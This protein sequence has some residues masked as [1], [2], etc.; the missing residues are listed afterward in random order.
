[1]IEA[2]RAQKKRWFEQRSRE[3]MMTA[4][5]SDSVSRLLSPL[6]VRLEPDKCISNLRFDFLDR[7]CD[8]RPIGERYLSGDVNLHIHASAGEGVWCF[9]FEA[10]DSV[11]VDPLKAGMNGDAPI[12]LTGDETRGPMNGGSTAQTRHSRLRR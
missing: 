7:L 3:T 6:E 2:T 4:G 9:T 1:M 5:G 11:Q 10:V 12:P 8:R